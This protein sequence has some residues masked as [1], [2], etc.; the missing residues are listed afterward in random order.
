VGGWVDGSEQTIVVLTLVAHAKKRRVAHLF[1][2]FSRFQ[3][4]LLIFYFTRRRPRFDLGARHRGSR[5]LG[6]NQP[7]F[8][9]RLR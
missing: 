9:D 4:R 8:V 7:R 2:R 5:V 3:E 6:A 1:D